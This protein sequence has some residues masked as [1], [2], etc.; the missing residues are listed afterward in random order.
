MLLAILATAH[1]FYETSRLDWQQNDAG[2]RARGKREVVM[3]GIQ[4]MASG[5]SRK[6]A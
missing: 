1:P 4:L 5:K 2:I 3:C 6:T